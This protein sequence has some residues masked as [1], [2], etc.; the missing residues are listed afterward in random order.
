GRGSRPSSAGCTLLRFSAGTPCVL[1]DCP[2]RLLGHRDRREPHHR[3]RSCSAGSSL[4]WD[5]AS[6]GSRSA[7]WVGGG[8]LLLRPPND[9]LRSPSAIGLVAESPSVSTR[10]KVS[11]TVRAEKCQAFS[12]VARSVPE[13]TGVECFHIYAFPL[14]ALFFPGIAHRLENFYLFAHSV[15][16]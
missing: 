5:R 6:S 7:E 8:S 10:I 14:T 13:T 11:R 1:G 2:G 16:N 12:L 15:S 4:V 3:G 9:E